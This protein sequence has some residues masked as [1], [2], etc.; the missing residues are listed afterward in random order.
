MSGYNSMSP[1][2][3]LLF[4]ILVVIALALYLLP[5]IIVGFR[6]HHNKGAIIATNILLGWTFIGWVAAF[7]WA[8]SSPAPATIVYM[9]K[10]K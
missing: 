8:C 2:G 6:K 3:Q 7:I 4:Q 9:N 5:T 1:D 10:D